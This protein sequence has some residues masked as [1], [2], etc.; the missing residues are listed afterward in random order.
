VLTEFVPVQGYP[1]L[2][3]EQVIVAADTAR[4]AIGPSGDH[5]GQLIAQPS[6]DGDV[7]VAGLGFGRPPT[8]P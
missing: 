6:G 8:S 4:F 5:G 2:P 7:T 3:D 1:A